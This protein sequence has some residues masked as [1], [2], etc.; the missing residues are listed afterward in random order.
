[1]FKSKITFKREASLV[2]D[3]KEIYRPKWPCICPYSCT[4][5][6]TSNISF[7]TPVGAPPTAGCIIFRK[8]SL[9]L[10]RME[11]DISAPFMADLR[12]CTN[13]PLKS[14]SCKSWRGIYFLAGNHKFEVILIG[15][16]CLF[17]NSNPKQFIFHGAVQH[18]ITDIRSWCF[19][20]SSMHL[21]LYENHQAFGI[22]LHLLM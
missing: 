22:F 14:G 20:K 6:I 15:P 3:Q 7:S 1:M 19:D 9:F 2:A 11:I 13:R 8:L 17:R 16:R 5:H 4:I 12:S 10:W 21:R 18:S